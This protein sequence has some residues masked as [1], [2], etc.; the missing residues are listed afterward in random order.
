MGTSPTYGS[1]RGMAWHPA[2]VP[3]TSMEAAIMSSPSR[4]ST[5][6]RVHR[7][8]MRGGH[9]PGHMREL[10]YDA[11]EARRTVTSGQWWRALPATST[12]E[13]F[14]HPAEQRWWGGLTPQEQARWLTG[15]LWNC[16]DTLPGD[17]C[18]DL[19]IP[20]G[21]TVAQCVRV[22]RREGATTS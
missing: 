18:E 20:R 19:D 4:L 16:T 2:P 14:H 9:A 22:L 5:D 6:V 8:G 13:T 11:L 10:L 3:A 17:F 12:G 7:P 21:S 1:R 15:Q